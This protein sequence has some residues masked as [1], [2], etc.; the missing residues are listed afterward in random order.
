MIRVLL[1]DDHTLFRDGIKSLLDS[2][3]DITIIGETENGEGL[4]RKY[5]ELKPDVVV[6]DISMPK[7]PGPVAAKIILKRDKKA[8]ILFL[9]QHIEDNYIYEALKC[10]ALGLIGKNIVKNELVLAINTVNKGK[11]YFVGRTDEYLQLILKKFDDIREKN[12][13]FLLS[14]LTSREN[15]VLEAIGEG[16]SRDE[17]AKKLKIG[18]KTFDAHKYNIM[19]KL[20]MKKKSEIIKYALELK[21]KQRY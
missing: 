3:K 12:G 18:V 17:I 19:A 5:F 13:H 7:K 6:T 1:A 21:M 14:H 20:G 10:K 9:S 8:K 4:V 2:E 11:Y 16:L 15:E